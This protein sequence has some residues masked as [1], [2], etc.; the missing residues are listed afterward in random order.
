MRTLPASRVLR[1][2]TTG[3]GMYDVVIVGGSFAGLAVA[4]RS[5]EPLLAAAGLVV[6]RT[7]L[8]YRLMGKY[9]AASG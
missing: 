2:P 8:K 9:L 6:S 7:G 1:F 4:A 3:G 5:P